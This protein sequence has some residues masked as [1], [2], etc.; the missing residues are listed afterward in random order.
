MLFRT[1]DFRCGGRTVRER[2]RR[3]ARAIDTDL[4]AQVKQPG[5]SRRRGSRVGQHPL[6]GFN[7]LGLLQVSRFSHLALRIILQFL[8]AEHTLQAGCHFPQE[9]RRV[10]GDIPRQHVDLHLGEAVARTA[11][12]PFD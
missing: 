1:N 10:S 6:V 9:I 3:F 12:D 5:P 7:E 4:T 2:V 11:L 8:D